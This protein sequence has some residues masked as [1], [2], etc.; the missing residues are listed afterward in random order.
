[1]MVSAYVFRHHENNGD[2]QEVL[3]ACKPDIDPVDTDNPFAVRL[4]LT[5][6]PPD[7]QAVWQQ[8]GQTDDGHNDDQ[9][10]RYES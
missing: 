1:M 5:K 10:Q 3:R 4:R 2:L 9:R 8:E 7:T 6:L